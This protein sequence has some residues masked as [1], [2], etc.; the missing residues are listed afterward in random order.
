MLL[1][2]I[3]RDP[4]RHARELAA[5]TDE[6]AIFDA[7]TLLSAEERAVAAL[8]EPA[9]YPTVERFARAAATRIV[10]NAGDLG[11]PPGPWI[12]AAIRATTRAL[13]LRAITAG[14]T[15]SFAR[16]AALDYL[17][18]QDRKE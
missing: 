2:S 13:F 3:V 10:S 18:E 4:R 9:V 16:R 1:A 14:E 7:L 12:G 8:V 5:L 11:V 15:A 17:R 6:A